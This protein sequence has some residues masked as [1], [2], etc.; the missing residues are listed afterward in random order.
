VTETFEAFSAYIEKLALQHVIV[1]VLYDV[2][3][4]LI[5]SLE[6][7]LKKI[8]PTV[9]VLFLLGW[10]HTYA[11]NEVRSHTIWLFTLVADSQNCRHAS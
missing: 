8:Q 5:I 6:P 2:A 3:C 11:H 1:A 10:L 9:V 7:R 4:R